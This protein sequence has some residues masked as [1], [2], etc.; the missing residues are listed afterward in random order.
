VRRCLVRAMYLSAPGEALS[1]WG[2]ITSVELYL[3]NFY[4]IAQC[5]ALMLHWKDIFR[6]YFFQLASPLKFAKAS[7][8]FTDLEVCR[9]CAYVPRRGLCGSQTSVRIAAFGEDILIKA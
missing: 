6:Y 3:L 4:F 1:T 9:G 2:A 5:S 8:G 7:R